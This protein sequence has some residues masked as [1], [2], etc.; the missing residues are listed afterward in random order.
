MSDGTTTPVAPETSQIPHKECRWCGYEIPASARLC[1]ECKSYQSAWRSVTVYVAS[2]A[3]AVALAASAITFIAGNWE[4]TTQK[5][6]SRNAVVLVYLNVLPG[7]DRRIIISNSND[8]PVFVSSV[9]IYWRGGSEDFR[10]EK[11]VQPHEFAVVDDREDPSWHFN[12]FIGTTDGVPIESLLQA[13]A[14]NAK[15]E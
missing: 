2:I 4:K 12:G 14:N 1:K 15:Q 3:G 13:T 11:T 7:H 5:L 6:L 9:A 10:F 8:Y